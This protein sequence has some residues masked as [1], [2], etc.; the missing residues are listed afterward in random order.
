MNMPRLYSGA[1]TDRPEVT[2]LTLPPIPEVIWQQPRETHLTTIIN[3]F[4]SE[5]HKDTH[6]PKQKNDVEAQT[7]PIKETSSKVSGSDSKSSLDN[8]TR[9]IPVQCPNDSNKQQNEI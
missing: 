6:M 8:Q 5:T 3:D 9:S 2:H 1:A 4:T 7:S